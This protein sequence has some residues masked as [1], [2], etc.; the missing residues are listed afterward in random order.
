MTTEEPCLTEKKTLTL[1]NIKLIL[2]EL[3]HLQKARPTSIPQAVPL[4]S[5][6]D[7]LWDSYLAECTKIRDLEMEWHMLQSSNK[8]LKAGNFELESTCVVKGGIVRD[9]QQSLQSVREGV[10][11]LFQSMRGY[12]TFLSSGNY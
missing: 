2:T 3:I 11:G 9:N 10:L 1:T 7:E 6:L 12:Q 8:L 5:L 4:I